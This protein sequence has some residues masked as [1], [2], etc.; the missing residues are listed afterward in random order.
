MLETE[1]TLSLVLFRVQDAENSAT[2]VLMNK[3]FNKG[4]FMVSAVIHEKEYI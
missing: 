1:N 2:S 3:L 4:V